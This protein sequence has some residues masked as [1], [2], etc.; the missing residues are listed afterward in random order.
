MAASLLLCCGCAVGI[1]VF[2]QVDH[3]AFALEGKLNDAVD[4]AYALAEPVASVFVDLKF[5]A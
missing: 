1:A 2:A 4:H 3:V 5:C